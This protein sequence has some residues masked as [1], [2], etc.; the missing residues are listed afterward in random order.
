MFPYSN[1]LDTLSRPSSSSL[2]CLSIK[3]NEKP[4]RE[5]SVRSN[6]LACHLK[7]HSSNLESGQKP[8]VNLVL[9]E[10][11]DPAG[12]AM[13]FQSTDYSVADDDELLAER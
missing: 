1:R 13:Y 10:F 9:T 2:Y 7:A 3:R 5:D 4:V 6:G 11:A 8:D 12:E